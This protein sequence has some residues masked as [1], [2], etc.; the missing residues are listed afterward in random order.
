MMSQIYTLLEE[1]VNQPEF[2]KKLESAKASKRSTA[3]MMHGDEVMHEEWWETPQ[4]AAIAGESSMH[5]EFTEVQCT[6]KGLISLAQSSE[7][8]SCCLI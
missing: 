7:A 5:E 6:C 2:L 8:F 1:H 4:G 3:I